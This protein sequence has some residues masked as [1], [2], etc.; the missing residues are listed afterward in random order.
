MR[1]FSVA[2]VFDNGEDWTRVQR[3][4]ARSG[5]AAQ[6]LDGCVDVTA[7][8]QAS[9]LK[10]IALLL[11]VRS[12]EEPD[13]TDLGIEEGMRTFRVDYAWLSEDLLDRTRGAWQLLGVFST[14]LATISREEGI[15]LPR[16]PAPRP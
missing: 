6:L 3:F 9:G 7:W 8:H 1:W 11:Y 2:A 15:P 12:R 4:T 5:A 14:I 13:V 10:G 16:L